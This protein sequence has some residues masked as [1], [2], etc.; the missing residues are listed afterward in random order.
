MMLDY[1][2]QF[3]VENI[4]KEPL[5][6]TFLSG[7]LFGI[8]TIY[9]YL[10]FFQKTE[11]TKPLK[12]IQQFF[13]ITIP[14][15]GY[16]FLDGEEKGRRRTYSDA[17]KKEMKRKTEETKSKN[18]MNED[19]AKYFVETFLK[20]LIKTKTIKEL[21]NHIEIATDKINQIKDSCLK[22]DTKY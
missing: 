18:K 20:Y 4:L 9:M 16:D 7:Y 1:I 21:K 13:K 12:V 14:I 8:F 10:L 15:F 2:F 11:Y 5:V 6:I 19:L 17:Q 3:F 22:I